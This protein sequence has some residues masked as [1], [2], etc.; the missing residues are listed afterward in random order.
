MSYGKFGVGT[1]SHD[2]PIWLLN[3]YFFHLA[4]QFLC[5]IIGSH[6]NRLVIRKGVKLLVPQYSLNSGASCRNLT[7]RIN[8]YVIKKATCPLTYYLGVLGR[9]QAK[10]EQHQDER[11]NHPFA[12]APLGI[13]L[14]SHL[15]EQMDPLVP[16]GHKVLPNGPGATGL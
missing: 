1:K 10:D 7:V 16:H 4:S 6:V 2:K 8:V 13:I 3:L 12:H 5:P 14:R 11:I 15:M 9:H